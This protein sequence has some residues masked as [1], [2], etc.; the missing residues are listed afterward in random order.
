MI[1]V[2]LIDD[3]PPALKALSAKFRKHFPEVS[4]LAE[5]TNVADALNAIRELQPDI[6]CLDIE[7]GE[8][9]GFSLLE[10]VGDIFF[11]TIFTTAYNEYAIR[12]IRFNALDY[13]LKPV[14]VQELKEALQRF[15]SRRNTQSREAFRLLHEQMQPGRRKID[16]IALPTMEGLDFVAINDIIR[17]EGADNYSRVY[18]KGMP[19][20]LVSRTL[21][22]LEALLEEYGFFRVHHSHLINLHYVKRYIKGNGGT[23]IMQ[24]GA[25]VEVSTRK[26][27]SFISLFQNNFR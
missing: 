2:V 16:N 13:L 1:K 25:E 10:S 22:E 4:V 11:Y 6:V 18:L 5:C 26:K 15:S 3:E 24:D 21:K 14:N 7:M 9:D 8:I 27:Y 12:A 17:L 19:S 23:V 20:V